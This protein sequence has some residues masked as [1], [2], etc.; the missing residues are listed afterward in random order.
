MSTYGR[1]ISIAFGADAEVITTIRSSASFA[2][3]A[4]DLL[5]VADAPVTIAEVTMLVRAR[6]TK[7]M[8]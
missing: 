3:A 8:H 4:F 1:R 7:R 6:D 5:Y 2:R